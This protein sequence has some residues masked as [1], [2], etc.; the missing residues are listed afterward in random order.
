MTNITF[1]RKEFEKQ[2][3]ITQ[4][5]EE[6]I[7]QFGTPLEK[8]DKEKIE[9]EIFPNRPDLIPFE[10]F[11]RSFKKF[12]GK[13]PGLKRYKVNKPE[14]NYKIIVDKSVKEVRP[15]TVCAIVKNLKLTEDNIKDIIN[16][17]EKLALTIGRNRKKMGIGIY[18]LDKINL[19]ITYTAKDP[20]DIKYHPLGAQR[21]M[22]AS[23]IL[24]LHQTGIAY[25][26]LLENKTKYPIFID[27]SKKILSMPP[28]INSE[29]TGRIDLNTKEVFIE[30]TGH[31]KTTLEK[32]INII[33]TSLADIGGK[34][35]QMDI[36]DG[37]KSVTPDLTTQKMKISLENTNKLLGLS[38][39][40][41]EI[42]KLL[43]KMGHNYS[44][45]TVEVAA[46]RTDILHEV[47]IIEDIAIAYGYNKFIPEIPNIATAGEESKESIIKRKIAEILIGLNML[48]LSTYHLIKQEEVEQHNTIEAIKLTES[49]SEYKYL[50]PNL[51]V[52]MLR[53][54][55]ENKDSEYPQKVFEIGRV[56]VKNSQKETKIH[57]ND[58]LIIGLTPSNATECKQHLDYFF[59]MLNIP[60]SIKDFVHTMLIEGRTAA[61]IVNNKTIGYFGEVHPETLRKVGIKMPLS[62]AEISLEEIYN[63]IKPFGFFTTP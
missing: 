55:A 50:R 57:E 11:M 12:I 5:I 58:N 52:P 43:L 15:F 1:S 33:V 21:E 40:E 10:G 38:L 9:I 32:T 62:I 17:Q 44:N 51:L 31:D 60:Y 27:D 4:E 22:S 2:I 35:Y 47:D 34:I 61:I 29:N 28:I 24:M 14:K 18:P 16:T 26:H 37:K 39:T 46:W 20:K 42:G 36:I 45:K 49:K 25:K 7:T 8:I 54:L 53:I 56:F 63:I 30:C 23:E 59:K 48:E 3:K 13:D 41:A 19:P 6:K